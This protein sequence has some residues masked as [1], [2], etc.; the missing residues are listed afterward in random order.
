M[1][2]INFNLT[3]V[4]LSFFGVFFLRRHLSVTCISVVRLS[5]N[6]RKDAVTLI[7]YF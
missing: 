6:D 1:M 4:V 5:K 3:G 2:Q 7:G